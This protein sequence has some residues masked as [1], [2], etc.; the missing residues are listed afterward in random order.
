[1]NKIIYNKFGKDC[2]NIILDY[3]KD[4]EKYKICLD[5]YNKMFSMLFDDSYLWNSKEYN[6]NNKKVFRIYNK[7]TLKEFIY[8]LN[9]YINEKKEIFKLFTFKVNVRDNYNNFNKDYWLTN[10]IYEFKRFLNILENYNYLEI[11]NIKIQ[12]NEITF[13]L[14]DNYIKKPKLYKKIYKK[15]KEKLISWYN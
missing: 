7:L 4:L 2:G 3:K 5:T 11:Q 14:F 6:Y 9:Y 12:K 1:M 8:F 13:N 15:M 10:T